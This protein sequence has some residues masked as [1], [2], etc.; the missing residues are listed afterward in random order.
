MH[1]TPV[2]LLPGTLCTAAVFAHQ[3][4]ALEAAGATVEV[5][6]FGA[7]DSI[8]AMVDLVAE[9]VAPMQ[10]IAL[11]GFSMGGMVATAFAGRH[12]ERVD[13]LALLNSKVQADP[14]TRR[15]QRRQYV[16]EARRSSMRQVMERGFLRNYLHHQDP[17]HRE[18]ILSMADRSGVAAFEAQAKALAERPDLGR[19]LANLDCPVLILGAEQDMLCPPAEQIGMHETARQ[20]RLVMLEEC[21]HFAVLERPD[22]VNEALLAWYRGE[23]YSR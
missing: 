5:V 9:H 21:G 16:L 11:A 13:R 6:Q 1:D 12:P 22:A 20:S 23:G 2:I 10:Q 18:L 3:V 17:G 15:A 8:G 19:T 14:R 4:E 7:L